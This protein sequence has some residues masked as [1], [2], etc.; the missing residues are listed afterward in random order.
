MPE[1]L[2]I[3]DLLCLLSRERKREN[4][5]QLDK[6]D[7]LRRL[8]DMMSDVAFSYHEV[9]PICPGQ[10]M[11]NTRRQVYLHLNSRDHKAK[12]QEAESFQDDAYSAIASTSLM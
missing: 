9:C 7:S 12:Q 11:L 4:Q 5:A 8:A 3:D 10:Q 6:L 2:V 1:N